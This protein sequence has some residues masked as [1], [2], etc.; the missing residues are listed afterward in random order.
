V[1][2][3]RAQSLLL[4]GDPR[5]RMKAGVCLAHELPLLVASSRSP[6][7]HVV[8]DAIASKPCSPKVKALV[9]LVCG[10]RF[11]EAGDG[12]IR[13]VGSGPAGGRGIIV[14]CSRK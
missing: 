5:R 10:R 13:G 3:E 2:E 8:A 6:G 7:V 12:E 14:R 9:K 4:D 1:V 11:R